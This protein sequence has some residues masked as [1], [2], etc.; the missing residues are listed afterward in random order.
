[1]S[2]D[3]EVFTKKTLQAVAETQIVIVR[4]T[5]TIRRTREIIDGKRVVTKYGEWTNSKWNRPLANDAIQRPRMRLIISD[6]SPTDHQPPTFEFFPK[7]ISAILNK[8][9]L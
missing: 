2:S 1:M 4:S 5:D 6:P 3:V 7:I 9:L 8:L